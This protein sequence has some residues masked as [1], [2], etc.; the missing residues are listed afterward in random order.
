[1]CVKKPGT[2]Y[3]QFVKSESYTI[4]G[5]GP[6]GVEPFKQHAR[7]NTTRGEMKHDMYDVSPRI[8]LPKFSCG[9][10]T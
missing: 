4:F 7:Y 1:M 9:E 10:M 3:K 8:V 6:F 5:E 2:K